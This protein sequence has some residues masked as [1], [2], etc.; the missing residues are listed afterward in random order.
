MDWADSIEDVLNTAREALDGLG[1][2]NVRNERL[3]WLERQLANVLTQ[4]GGMM[5]DLESGLSVA[6]MGYFG[7]EEFQGEIDD[8]GRQIAN[9]RSMIRIELAVGR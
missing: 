4:L 8:F 2:G 6:D 3:H 5:M 1:E 9:L 7:D